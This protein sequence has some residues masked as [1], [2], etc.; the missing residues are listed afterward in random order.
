MVRPDMIFPNYHTL[1]EFLG[2]LGIGGLKTFRIGW[3]FFMGFVLTIGSLLNVSL[4]DV[5]AQLI[6]ERLLP[7]PSLHASS[8]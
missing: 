8:P 2:S 4:P 1:L 5:E 7:I 6:D 3:Y